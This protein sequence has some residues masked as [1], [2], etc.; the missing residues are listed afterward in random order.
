M[1]QP[2]PDFSSYSFAKTF[3]LPAVLVFLIPALTLAFF[4]HAQ[5]TYDAAA[6]KAVL[7]Q[8][9][10]DPEMTP[11]QKAEATQ[12][13]EEVP[14]SK[15][16][17]NPEIAGNESSEVRWA[18]ASFHWMIVLSIV[19]IASGVIVFVLGGICVLLSL[20]S[21]RAQYLS[22]S[23][24]WHVLRIFGAFQTLAQAVMVIALS[25]WVTAIWF[26]VYFVKIIF[27]A[28]VIALAGVWAVVV[29]IFKKPNTDFHVEGQA[30]DEQQAPALWQRLRALCSKVG[31][32]PPDQVIAGIDDN[33][34][35]TEH[36]VTVGD[37]VYQGRTLYV[38]LALLK[39]LDGE[40]ADAVMAHEMAHFSG[41]DTTFSKKISPLLTRYELYLQ[42]LG[43]NLLTRPVFYFMACFR[44]LYELS[45]GRQ[46][47][48]REFRADRV[49][50]ET[51]SPKAM[52]SALLRIAAYS[53]YRGSIEEKLFEEQQA[54]ENADIAN[55]IE[56]GFHAYA[57]SFAKTEDLAKLEM[58]HP[59]DSHPPTIQRME[60]M[61]LEFGPQTAHSHLHSA[62]DGLWYRNIAGAEELERQQWDAYE[63][64][65]RKFHEE[66][67]AYR[68]M[69]RNE[70]EQAAVEKFFPPVQFAGKKGEL[71]IT[72][73]TLQYA[74]WKDDLDWSEVAN[75]SVNDNVL[76]IKSAV[77][78][79][80]SRTLKFAHFG[81]QQ[82][83]VLEA[84]NKYY[85]RHQAA[86]AYQKEQ[87]AAAA[88]SPA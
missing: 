87:A 26:E 53:K 84:L 55:R 43:S 39:Q 44:G 49:A 27:I 18:Y 57:V 16:M 73:K 56:S 62:G 24:G 30:I 70:T 83:E 31:T 22:L 48:Q 50:A 65:F 2:K 59:F 71:V 29:A 25:F 33:F 82:S 67:L 47:R 76:T 75:L 61:G 9:A 52:V 79:K 78:E 42:A 69:P 4:W 45:L 85:I 37:K 32:E 10:A 19:C 40:E 12:F 86:D 88:G 35:V 41:Q 80:K 6:R 13:F 36:P 5:S 64:R 74:E 68:L 7:A 72:Y 60:A 77:K 81:K 66:M 11:E 38:S 15:L 1:E 63:E 28:G 46:S 51:T 14:F 34:F 21:Q 17:R 3:V 20:R 58:A 23:A 8:I 54:L